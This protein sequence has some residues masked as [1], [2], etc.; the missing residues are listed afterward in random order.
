[1]ENVLSPLAIII[2]VSAILHSQEAIASYQL[3]VCHWWHLMRDISWSCHCSSWSYNKYSYYLLGDI[4]L[5]NVVSPSFWELVRA[6]VVCA[7]RDTFSFLIIDAIQFQCRSSPQSCLDI[8]RTGKT[9][10]SN[11]YYLIYDRSTCNQA[12]PNSFVIYCD[13]TSQP[14]YAWTLIESFSFSNRLHTSINKAFNVD[15]SAN[16]NSPR[17]HWSLYRMGFNRMLSVYNRYQSLGSRTL[18]RATCNFESFPRPFPV[19]PLDVV[20]SSFNSINIFASKDFN[21]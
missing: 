13:F 11:Q 9:P 2:D 20:Y 5:M 18:W 7:Y 21:A 4:Y 19:S 14:G 12:C 1:M 16:S 17:N 6:N 15:A 10:V 3:L 8:A